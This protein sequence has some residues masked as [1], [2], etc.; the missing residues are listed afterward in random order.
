MLERWLLDL[1]RL[2]LAVGTLLDT[3]GCFMLLAR[4]ADVAT[5][6]VMEVKYLPLGV[7]LA[8]AFTL[9][10]PLV[11]AFTFIAFVFGSASGCS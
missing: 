2:D 5:S 7:G 3:E 10:F 9:A 6:S 4:L 8:F 11:S 1:D